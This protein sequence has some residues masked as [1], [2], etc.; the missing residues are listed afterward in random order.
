MA[1]RISCFNAS[2]FSSYQ[3]EKIQRRVTLVKDC[4]LIASKHQ[5]RFRYIKHLASYVANYIEEVE[6]NESKDRALAAG[7]T[8]SGLTQKVDPG[9]FTRSA[10]YKA[11]LNE[12][13]QRH[14]MVGVEKASEKD[15]VNKFRVQIADLSNEVS[16]L[17]HELAKQAVLQEE[18][19]GASHA[20]KTK[21]NPDLTEAYFM[22]MAL[23]EEFSD[24][25]EVHDGALVVANSLRKVL[26][27]EV[28]F[29]VYQLWRKDFIEM[30]RPKLQ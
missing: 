1:S 26:I 13:M 3:R 20:T 18:R 6:F 29:K 5:M 9:T 30:R 19:E 22:V 25:V 4:L 21:I 11:V 8:H 17:R 23:L 16:W 27:G 10:H 2:N 28:R 12:W 14:S 7:V 24:F 15:S